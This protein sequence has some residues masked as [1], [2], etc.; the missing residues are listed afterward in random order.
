MATGVA[1]ALNP[2]TPVV[3][4][5]RVQA[6][7]AHRRV[8]PDPIRLAYSFRVAPTRVP[9][10][11]GRGTDVQ[12]VWPSCTD[13]RLGEG[14]DPSEVGGEVQIEVVALSKYDGGEV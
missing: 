2:A 10:I 1:G 14:F 13:E 11:A 8:P 5:T 4:S 7:P 12:R 6:L 9:L 3:V